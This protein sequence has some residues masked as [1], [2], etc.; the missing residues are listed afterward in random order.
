MT[1]LLPLLQE[2]H[3]AKL[4][5]LLR[6]LAG[7]RLIRQYDINN[8]YQYLINRDETHLSWLAA[9]IVDLGGSVRDSADEPS[10]PTGNN[11]VATARAVLED[12]SREA[13][14][15]VDM[16]RPRVDVMTHARHRGMLRVILGET[17]EQKRSFEQALA[18]Q[19]D[20]L[21]RRPDHVG[22]RVGEV[23]PNRWV[24]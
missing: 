18:G 5:T 19:L 22:A 9:A 10:R 14:T 17:L 24:E 21:G 7:A 20:L 3:E 4:N 2:F 1:D 15:F 12:D 23:L 6:H 11:P 13:Q 16:W 8:A